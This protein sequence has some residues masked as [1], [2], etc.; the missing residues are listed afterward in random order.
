MMQGVDKLMFTLVQVLTGD[1]FHQII[2]DILIYVPGAWVYFYAYIAIAGLVLMNLVTAI[3]VDNAME[4][5]RGDKEQQFV[6][7]EA[8]IKRELR[9]LKLLFEMIDL[10]KSGHLS[11]DEFNDSFNDPEMRKKWM[12]LDFKP[13]DGKE[14]FKLLSDSNGEVPSERF[15]EG[16]QKM[17]GAAQARDMF[18]LESHVQNLLALSR[19]P[20]LDRDGSSDFRGKRALASG[21]H[22]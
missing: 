3:I 8:S 14:L 9:E 18:R 11:W 22:V 1:S 10:D 7:K 16:L 6:E 17:K 19:G 21:S 13:E 20:L 4:T 12:L 5:S 2:R 15:F